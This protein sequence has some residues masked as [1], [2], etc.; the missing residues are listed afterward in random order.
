MI[1]IAIIGAG[2]IGSRHLQGVASMELEVRI[3][4]VDSCEK[5]LT[6]AKKLYEQINSC[7]AKDIE[8]LSDINHLAKNLDVVII[9]TSSLVRLEV[10]DK[11][12]CRKSV[13]NLILEKFLFPSL[14][15]YDIAEKLISLHGCKTW[16]NCIRQSMPSYSWLKELLSGKLSYYHLLGGSWGLGCSGIHFLDLITYL[17]NNSE[18]LIIEN[19]LDSGFI[20]SKRDEYI[21][22]T[23]GIT[24]SL[25]KC[26]QFSLT[27]YRN[28]NAPIIAFMGNDNL[29][30]IVQES[31]H[32]I[33]LERKENDWK[34]EILEFP[35][36]Y[37]SSLTGKLVQEIIKTSDCSLPKYENS[38]ILHKALLTT[39]L[40]HYNHGRKEKSEICP[41]T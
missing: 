29:R 31:Q 20:K 37:V 9:A 16:V 25:K 23:G 11:L 21:E 5:A 6:N 12:L 13:N 24:G 36:Q 19:K 33:L 2:G 32:K 14:D 4:V 30:C 26:E 8:W 22:F 27:S 18:N 39:F 3:Q 7:F 35:M 17:V 38:A 15:E 1:N 40:D 28:N 34:Q 10:L 41:I